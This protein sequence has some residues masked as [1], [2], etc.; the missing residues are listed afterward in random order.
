MRFHV[1]G[2]D[3]GVPSM[4]YVIDL[5]G[6]ERGATSSSNSDP[7]RLQEAI[8]IN[9]SLAALKECIRARLQGSAHASWRSSKLTMVLRRAFDTS[10]A[11]HEGAQSGPEPQLT[12]LACV[13]PNVIDVEDTLGTLNYVTPFRVSLAIW[14]ARPRLIIS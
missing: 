2:S 12:V 5:A 1:R 3:G 6:S 9:K 4:L 11:L 10:Q 7:Q 8:E 13:S 14:A